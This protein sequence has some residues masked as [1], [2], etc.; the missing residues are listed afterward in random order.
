MSIAR[1]RAELRVQE[2]FSVPEAAKLLRLDVRTVR[3]MCAGGEIP[4]AVM[5]RKRWRVPTWWLR[6]QVSPPERPAA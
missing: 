5:L 4:G 6:K 1:L 2:F 3:K